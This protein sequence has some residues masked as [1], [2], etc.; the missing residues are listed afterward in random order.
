MGQS[1]MMGISDLGRSEVG[2]F[3]G[4][5]CLFKHEVRKTDLEGTGLEPLRCHLTG[6]NLGYRANPFIYT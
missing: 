4:A 2:I 3:I 6:I 1:L 5:S